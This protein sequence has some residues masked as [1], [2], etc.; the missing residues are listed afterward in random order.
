MRAPDG[1]LI[2]GFELHDLEKQSLI[3]YDALSVE[4]ADKIQI[5]LELLQE[6][7]YLEPGA[8]LKET[9]FKALD[10]YNIER[11]AK[12][13]WDMVNDHKI[14]SLFQMEQQSGIQGIRLTNPRSVDDL[15]TLNSVIR[16]MAQEGESETPLE[17]Y[18]RFRKDKNAFDNEMTAYGLTEEERKILHEH[19][20]IS[21]GLS[22]AQ[23]QFMKLVQI[24][25][26]GG[27]DLQFADKL[28]KAIAK[29]NPKEYEELE[30][31]YYE[32]IEERGLRKEFADYVWR[33][34]IAL[35]KGYGF[36]ASHTLAYSLVALQEMNL[37]YKYPIIFWNTANLIVDSAGV[38]NDDED[39]N[40][41]EEIYETIETPEVVEDTVSIYEPE[42]WEEYDYVDLPDRSGKIKKKN[43][44]IDFGK[45]ATAI[46]RFKEEGIIITSPDINNS[47]YSFT[48]DVENNEIVYGLRGITRVS[49]DL[50]ETIMANRPYASFDD[51][52][53][54]VKTNKLQMVNLIKSGAFDR[55]EGRPREDIMKDYIISIA[56]TKTK[57]TLANMPM[58]VER[59]LIAPEMDEYRKVYMFNK[60]LKGCKKGTDYI[61]DDVSLNFYNARYDM[62]LVRD[63]E[64][65][66]QKSW[67]AIYKKATKP[68]SE[69]IKLH[70]EEL[71]DKVNKSVIAEEF[72]KYASGSISK[73]EMDS[74]SFYYHDHEL[75]EAETKY[76]NFNKLP[77]QPEVEYTFHSK[78]GKEI[79]IYRLNLIAGT[80]IN[81]NKMKNTVTLLTQHG[82]VNIKIYKNQFSQYDKQIA[83]KGEDGKKKILEKSWFSRGTLLIVQ[84]IRRGNDFIPKKYKSSLN[85]VLMKINKIEDGKCDIIYERLEV[86]E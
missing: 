74:I 50:I 59:E 14:I 57:L 39:E 58:L 43:K 64:R 52:N 6:Y 27:W 2:S 48:P 15:S 72:E 77:E 13:M 24:P 73:W 3:K 49:S 66:A 55:L 63:G 65:I 46:G 18:A 7:G 12:E 23:E 22:I 61:L 28:R 9:Y 45:I 4:A 35:S 19:L 32:R 85:P 38:K 17:K 37:A 47:S 83:V 67:D 34:Q 78:D 36:N 79:K 11:N 81:K 8:N 42:D 76:S 71:L 80:V 70:Q 20:D 33:K 69:Y 62:S 60:Y 56:D 21:S 40:D 75:N 51:F 53:S 41:D 29:K 84:G 31:K 16:L 10:I 1:T 25:E 82:V 30:H 26:L 44:T 68:L 54:R 5:T 86:E